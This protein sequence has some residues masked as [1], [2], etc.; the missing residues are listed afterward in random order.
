[1]AVWDDI[2][3]AEAYLR[4]IKDVAHE[5]Y[6]HGTTTDNKYYG[7]PEFVLN[8]FEKNVDLE[9]GIV[10][11]SPKSKQAFNQFCEKYQVS[12][13]EGNIFVTID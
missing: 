7:V 1:P 12:D 10:Y 2:G 8:D 13:A 9:T 11:G 6:V 5:T 3:T 4:L